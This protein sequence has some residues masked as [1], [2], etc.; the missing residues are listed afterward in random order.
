MAIKRRITP[1]STG[2]KAVEVQKEQMKKHL[3]IQISMMSR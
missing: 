3:E 1:G 2:L